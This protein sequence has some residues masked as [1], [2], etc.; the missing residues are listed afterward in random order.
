[1][2]T[3]A[4]SG[5]GYETAHALA[6]DGHIVYAAARR[7][8]RMEPLRESGVRVLRMDVTD[9]GSM[10]AGV[11]SVLQA[12]QRI[13]VLVNNAGYGFFGAVE[14][15]SM[16][17]ARH[18][19]DVNVFGL[20][21]MCQLVL[22]AM[23]RQGSGRIVN[24]SSIAGKSVYFMGGWYS[25]SKYAVEALSDALR[26]E[27]R[28]FGIEVVLVEPGPVRTD[29][30]IIAAQ[31]LSETSFATDYA[32][33]GENWAHTLRRAW[34]SQWLSSPTV[35]TRAVCHAVNSRRPL[36]RYRRGR[37]AHAAVLLHTLLPARWWDAMMRR[38]AKLRLH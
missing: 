27:V 7:V 36:V 21:R 24:I 29:W 26:M 1:M 11:K 14:N 4:S 38:C 19:L 30:G 35:I 31:H 20:A 9:D 6:K 23:R 12:E 37:L 3:G 33:L 18:Q 34:Q 5:I 13:D 32:S 28:P 16:A 8:E 15:V 17:E 2:I 10:C 25:V 22:P